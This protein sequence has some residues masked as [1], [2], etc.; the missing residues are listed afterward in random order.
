MAELPL[1][2]AIPRFKANEDRMNRFVNGDDEATWT[3]SGGS[4]EPSISKFLKDKDTE[5][6]LQAGGI[7]EQTQTAAGE[8]EA[9]QTAAESAQVAAEAAAATLPPIGDDGLIVDIDGVRETKSFDETLTLLDANLRIELGIPPIPLNAI[10]DF[11]PLGDTQ[12]LYAGRVSDGGD[13]K[14]RHFGD[15]KRTTRG[16][17]HMF[18]R[19]ADEHGTGF[20]GALCYRRRR[21]GRAWEAEVVLI[22]AQGAGL[23]DQ[24]AIIAGVVPGTDR[25][26]VVY[27]ESPQVPTISSRPGPPGDPAN[28]NNSIGPAYLKTFHFDDDGDAF[29][30]GGFTITPATIHTTAYSWFQPFGTIKFHDLDG[31][32]VGYFSYFGQFADH[33]WDDAYR[34]EVME[35]R[36]NG[37]TFTPTVEEIYSSTVPTYNETAVVRLNRDISFAAGRANSGGLG[38]FRRTSSGGAWSL[39]GTLPGTD[40][41]DVAPSLD[42]AY[43][44]GRPYFVIGSCDRAGSNGIMKF[45]VAEVDD[46]YSSP[47]LFL[48]VQEASADDM[49]NA[50]GY[51]HTIVYPNGDIEWVEFREFVG[52]NATDIRIVHK[53][54]VDWIEGYFSFVPTVRG[55]TAAGTPTYNTV[56]TVARVQKVGK[57]VHYH[58]RVTLTAKTGMTGQYQISLPYVTKNLQEARAPVTL[59][60]KTGISQTTSTST[61]AD[62]DKGFTALCLQN[63]AWIG[64]YKDVDSG[65]ATLLNA[66][67][68]EVAAAHTITFN[69]IYETN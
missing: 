16:T 51:Q 22:P 28:Y 65:A 25:V 6:N 27:S 60:Y 46:V 38:W 63:L 26:V 68:S 21:R 58:G 57:R 39:L 32:T 10:P 18:Y 31:E 47:T 52:D 12:T 41:Q 15:Y 50:S 36:D 43:V 61:P 23:N 8:A 54:L 49:G 59:G 42:L 20:P 24:R 29:Y 7:L 11:V 17:R 33:E 5:I 40:D 55:A 3:T 4:T 56:D 37:E 64:I 69:V 53:R 9:A 34:V 1:D 45:R 48:N 13:G 66:N 2:Q 19:K 35:V 62:S 14:H 30:A 44:N 67:D